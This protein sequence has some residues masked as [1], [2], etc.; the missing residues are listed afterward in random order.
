MNGTFLRSNLYDVT[1]K[2]GLCC[3]R[4]EKECRQAICGIGLFSWFV[5]VITSDDSYN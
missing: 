2:L 1:T 3:L 5:F 4:T